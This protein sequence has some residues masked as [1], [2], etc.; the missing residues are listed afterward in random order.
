MYTL[1]PRRFFLIYIADV[2]GT[3]TFSTGFHWQ[4]I[5]LFIVSVRLLSCSHFEL[6]KIVPALYILYKCLEYVSQEALAKHMWTWNI[7]ARLQMCH[8]A[9]MEVRGQPETRSLCCLAAVYT[10][11]DGWRA[12]RGYPVTPSLLP[13]HCRSTAVTDM[14]YCSRL[15]LS[16]GDLYSRP[17]AYMANTLPSHKPSHR[18]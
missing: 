8:A 10:R 12:S 1:L 11:L 17:P 9:C 6:I 4:S 13:A 15:Y 7:W 14:S 2:H 3:N 18:T 5:K 16:L